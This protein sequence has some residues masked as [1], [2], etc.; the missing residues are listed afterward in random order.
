MELDRWDDQ[1]T[2]WDGVSEDMNRFGLPREDGNGEGKTRG[3]W[4]TQ[5]H[6]ENDC[7]YMCVYVSR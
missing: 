1:E 5:V 6:L 3:N 7:V 2:W 4:L